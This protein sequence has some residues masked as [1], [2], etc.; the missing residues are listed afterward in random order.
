MLN[1]A[2]ATKF[3]NEHQEFRDNY[4][5]IPL[6]GGEAYREVKNIMGFRSAED[7]DRLYAVKPTEVKKTEEVKKP[8]RKG[9]KV[10][11]KGKTVEKAYAQD[12]ID[13]L[14]AQMTI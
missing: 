6:K 7:I 1:W 13:R 9:R 14:N 11:K 12:D 10:A 5:A 2:K 8:T 3:W 4:Y